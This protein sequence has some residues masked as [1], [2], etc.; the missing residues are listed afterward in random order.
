MFQGGRGVHARNRRFAFDPVR[1]RVFTIGGLSAHADRSAL[2]GWLANF[3]KAPRE[4]WVV[5]GETLPAHSLCEAINQKAGWRAAVPNP[6]Q[7]VELS[8]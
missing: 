5:H 8:T 7:T 6:G 3:R 4:T 1:A 2:L